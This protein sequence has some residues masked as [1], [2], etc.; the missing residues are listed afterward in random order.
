MTMQLSKTFELISNKQ[1]SLK[2][3]VADAIESA[4]T[5]KAKVQ[6]AS[7]AVLWHIEK[8]GNWNVANHNVNKLV[9]ELGEN[10][11]RANALIEWFEVFGG[12]NYNT[13]TKQFD[14]FQ[15]AEHIRKNFQNAQKTLWDTMRK[16]P[17]Y[18]GFDLNAQLN[19]LLEQAV[20]QNIQRQKWMESGDKE[21]IAKAEAIKADG[22]VIE[23][24]QM[25]VNTSEANKQLNGGAPEQKREVVHG[26][27]KAVK[28]EVAPVVGHYQALPAPKAA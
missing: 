28:Q 7:V 16:E 3:L 27:K 6:V 13:E 20:K 21:K 5:M 18:Q 22:K 10:G 19:K 25:L 2:S 1:V 23:Q 12:L 17:P 14:G 4:K 15:G 24:I 8:H 26:L 9:S 11:V